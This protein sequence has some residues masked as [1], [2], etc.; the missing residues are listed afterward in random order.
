MADASVIGKI[1]CRYCNVYVHKSAYY[2]NHRNGYC[3]KYMSHHKAKDVLKKSRSIASTYNQVG[4]S[5]GNKNMMDFN[6]GK[7]DYFESN[8]ENHAVEDY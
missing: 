3:L 5:G 2:Q 1:L 6:D 4:S 7:S 8:T